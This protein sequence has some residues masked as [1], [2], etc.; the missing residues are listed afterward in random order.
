MWIYI[1]LQNTGYRVLASM[2]TRAEHRQ[3]WTESPILWDW[4]GR[5]GGSG[6]RGSYAQKTVPGKQMLDKFN[7]LA[8]G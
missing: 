2:R 6:R 8:I 1:C 7:N 5:R 3:Q 4:S